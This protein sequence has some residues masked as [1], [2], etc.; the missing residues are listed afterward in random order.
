MRARPERAA[1]A[2]DPSSALSGGDRAWFLKGV[3]DV[4]AL[5]AWIVGLTMVGIGGLA[6]EAGFSAGVAM[7]STLLIWAGPGQVLFF[8]MAAQGAAWPTIALSISLSS[9]RFLPMTIAI[10]PLVRRPGQGPMSQVLAAHFVAVTVWSEGLRRL[11]RLPREGRAG[12]FFGFALGCIGLSVALTGLGH[13]L[14]G[15]LPKPLAAALLFISPVFFTVSLAGGARVP[16]DWLALGLGFALAP[17]FA[18]MIGGGFD[19]MAVGL[20]GGTLAYGV[21]RLIGRRR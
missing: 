16:T 19:L 9:V 20:V 2:M 15:A 1:V 10:L 6:R 5:P 7:L 18:A 17:V 21:G 4:L 14:A 12:Y 8:G 13:A 3:R 11:P